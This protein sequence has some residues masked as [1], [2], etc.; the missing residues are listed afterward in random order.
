MPDRHETVKPMALSAMCHR[1]RVP[2]QIRRSDF[3]V[4]Q[5]E[6]SPTRTSKHQPMAQIDQI[7]HRGSI[8][9][10]AGQPYPDPA[11]LETEC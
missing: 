8:R 11:K 5:T 1:E 10:N 6:A 7:N 9:R 2:F 4:G 3:R